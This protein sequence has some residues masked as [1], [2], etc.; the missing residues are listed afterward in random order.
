M[1]ISEGI[2]SAPVLVTGAALT[3]AGTAV[4]LKKLDYERMATVGMLAAAFFVAALVHVPIGPGSI[5]L[6]LNGLLG[7][8]LGWAAFPAILTALVLQAILFQFGG[9]TTLGVNTFLMAFPA[10]CAYWLLGPMVRGK[11]TRAVVA[12]FLAGAL[13]VALS[14]LI[15]AAALIST[16]EHFL[17]A[18]SMVLVA[19]VPLMAIEGLVTVFVIG[20][21]KKVQPELLKMG[22]S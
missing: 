7:L 17:K 12:A 19:H 8:L 1:H 4:G 20:F 15:M 9:I 14:G 10:V 18:A 2:L 13:A 22:G 6:I 21:L 11:G 3:A 5:H 16:G